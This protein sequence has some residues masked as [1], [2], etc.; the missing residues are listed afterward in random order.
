MKV[1]NQELL[2]V[3][4]LN[5]DNRYK[6]FIKKITDWDRVWGLY[7]NGWALAE[8]GQNEVVLPI[9]PAKEFALICANSN[10][11][12]Y[13]PES[14]SLSDLENDLLPSLKNDKVKV[15][16]FYT[17]KDKGIVVENDKLIDDLKEELKNYI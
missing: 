14:F 16:I 9:W 8:T 10:W 2:S 7:N 15:A 3:I 17:P 4:N 12:S 1:S 11:K 5:A 6:Y 13:T